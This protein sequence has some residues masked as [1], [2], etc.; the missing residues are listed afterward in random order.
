V[1]RHVL[2]RAGVRV[3]TASNGQVAIDLLTATPERFDAVLMD[4][5]MPGMD[6]YE[7]TRTIR[8][9]LG[10]SRLPVIALTADARSSE[11][12][13]SQLAG[14]SDFVS[15]PFE[16]DALLA[17]LR[18]QIFP[19]GG[20]PSSGRSESRGP[21]PSASSSWPQVEGIDSD[22][23][24]ANFDR[25]A[26]L[27]RTLLALFLRDSAQLAVPLDL[28]DPST[29]PVG[30]ALAH[31][32]RGGASQLGARTLAKLAAD[33]EEAC[34]AG[35]GS[36]ASLVMT[37]ISAEFSRLRQAAHELSGVAAPLAP[38]AGAEALAG[39]ELARVVTLLRQQDLSALAQIQAAAPG[40]RSLLGEGSPSFFG[41]IEQLRFQDAVRIL[42]QRVGR[43]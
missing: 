16:V 10:L 8:D 18:R 20:P 11:R 6:G 13:R 29:L 39:G 32:L 2:E 19:E 15:K 28:R 31:K 17:C 36:R 12:T 23:A 26:N 21:P 24:Q 25:D 30:L 4:V 37:E 34:R 3:T 14:M 33:C 7:A 43:S 27:F 40:L 41:C 22:E 42:E 1:A 35:D 38:G 5:Q 9:Q